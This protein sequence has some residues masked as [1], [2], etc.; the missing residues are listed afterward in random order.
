MNTLLI[1]SPLLSMD[2]INNQE[3][4]TTIPSFF[5]SLCQ[6]DI[7]G[8]GEAFHLSISHCICGTCG[9]ECRSPISARAH[10]LSHSKQNGKAS[11]NSD[12]S[13]KLK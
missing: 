2:S 11:R 3:I 9:L 1:A 12:L 10:F 4:E 7:K 5:C 13:T 8:S 6:K